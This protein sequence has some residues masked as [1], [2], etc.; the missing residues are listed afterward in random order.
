MGWSNAS[1]F[2]AHAAFGGHGGDKT[3]VFTK[4]RR[5]VASCLAGLGGGQGFQCNPKSTVEFID[6]EYR[7]HHA[8][9]F[10]IRFLGEPARGVVFDVS[11]GN[12]GLVGNDTVYCIDCH[13]GQ[14]VAVIVAAVEG[15]GRQGGRIPDFPEQCVGKDGL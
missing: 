10:H 4:Y 11:V 3:H 15:V 8:G 6:T 2:I 13:R 12:A 14:P 9:E 1:C 5:T 7:H